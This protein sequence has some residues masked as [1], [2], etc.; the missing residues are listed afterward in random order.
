MPDGPAPWGIGA[1]PPPGEGA[2]LAQHLWELIL[3]FVQPPLQLQYNSVPANSPTIGRRAGPRTVISPEKTGSSTETKPRQGPYISPTPA[4]TQVEGVKNDNVQDR[5]DSN[6]EHIARLVEK[7]QRGG[8]EAFGE[9]YRLHYEKL[10]K[11]AAYRLGRQS[12]EDAVNETFVRAFKGLSRYRATGAPFISWLYGIAHNVVVD[13]GN[14]QRRVE[15]RGEFPDMAIEPSLP[16]ADNIALRDAIQA[17]PQKQRQVIEMKYFLS[18][19]N[20]EV[21]AHLKKSPGAV[22]ALQW[23]ALESLQKIMGK[24]WTGDES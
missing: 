13:A 17:L 24:S 23:R 5:D 14:S 15:P 20:G 4:D 12:A 21:G 22:N 19:N 10:F 7:A 16:T 1:G 8:N 3:S 6:K 2:S 11:Y 9:I 18:M